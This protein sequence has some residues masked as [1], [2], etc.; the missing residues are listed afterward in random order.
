[1]PGRTAFRVALRR[2][3]H[4]LLDRPLVLD[5]P[6]AI[7]ILGAETAARLRT[8]P[9][10]FERG[11]ADAYLRAFVVARARCAEQQLEAARAAGVRQYVILGAGL[12][13]FA[14]RQPAG[15]PL[16]IWEVDHPDTQVWKRQL[17]AAA[18]IAV[19]AN[20][21]WAAVDFE[22]DSL[23]DRL[24]GSGF[25]RSAGAVFAWLG[26]TMYLTVEAI[27]A[28]LGHVAQAAGPQGGVTFDYAVDR[29]LLPPLQQAVF[30]RM[31]A[32]VEAAGEPWRTTFDPGRLAA[33]VRDLG[34]TSS[35]DAG[36]EALN[37]R[38]FA[39]R[40]DG[41]RV[42]GLARIMWAGRR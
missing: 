33:R 36:A 19:P 5:D 6:V 41:L 29:A 42:G 16:R 35:A 14:Y 34:F 32:R 38:Y 12:D 28:T 15:P 39:G 31:A 1:M 22:R 4:Q 17:L 27:D 3:A 7:P 25:D 20:L 21:A 24:A 30:D 10:A 18:G 2:A 13:T 11:P 8:D 23:G 37:A 9:S 26:V 40:S